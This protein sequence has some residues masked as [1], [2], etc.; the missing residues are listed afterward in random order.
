MLINTDTIPILSD[1]LIATLFRSSFGF[2]ESPIAVP[3]DIG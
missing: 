2:G 3:L 1:V